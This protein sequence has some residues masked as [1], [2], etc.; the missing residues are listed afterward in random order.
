MNE[1]LKELLEKQ[2]MVYTVLRQSRGYLHVQVPSERAY[3]LIIAS[4][5][6][7]GMGLLQLISAV[8]L[9]EDELFQLTWILENVSDTSVFMVSARYSR[10]ECSL[11]TLGGVWPTAVIFER[12]LHEMFGIDLRG[13]PRQCEDFLLEGWDEIPPM[14]RDFDTLEYSMSKFGHRPGREHIDPRRH[15]AENIGEWQTPVPLDEEER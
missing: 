1:N 9:I 3:E 2:G 6:I 11:P 5:E 4:R 7:C 15:I 8:D 13:N 10:V 12:E 14:R